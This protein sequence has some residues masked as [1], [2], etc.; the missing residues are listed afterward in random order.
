MGEHSGETTLLRLH[1]LLSIF[2]N[3]AFHIFIHNM[4]N[5]LVHN[6]VLN[7]L[8]SNLSVDFMDF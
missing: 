2:V 5:I 8:G 3:V 7:L 6:P 4:F 1:C